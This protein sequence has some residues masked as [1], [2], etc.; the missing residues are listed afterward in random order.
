M[1]DTLRVAVVGAGMA[2]QAHAFGYRN[3]SMAHGL[4]PVRVELAC[5]VDPNLPLARSVAE[6]YGFASA[7][8]ELDAVLADPSIDVVSVA[9]PNLVHAE[10]LPKVLA[11]GK[12][13]FTEKPL[14]RRV[15]EARALADLA[16]SSG[17]RTGV[18]FSFRR[19]P[20]LAALADA[21]HAGAIGDVY[22]ARAWYQADYA[23]DPEG[24]F[25]W[26]YSLAES[27]G[28][29]IL[30]IGS[31]A[32][33]ALQ[34]VAGPVSAVRGAC[35]STVIPK[36]PVPS[37][38]VVGHG[39]AGTTGEYAEVTNDD[40]AVVLF[41][42]GGG[43]LAHLEVSRVAAGMPN[44]LGVTVYGSAGHASFDSITGGEFHIFQS[45]VADVLTNGPRRVFTG[46][47]HPYFADVAPMPGG[48]V[49]TGYGE[50]FVAEIQE[51]LHSVLT[52]QPMST[53]FD[54]AVATMAVVDA[55]QQ[56]AAS[57]A[58]REVG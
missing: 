20:G 13:L 55:A 10:V 36:R 37:R 22:S 11:A 50:A 57:G 9:L 47:Q 33:D 28:G 34:F 43:G 4:G 41:E 27:G 2:G 21:V 23:A 1:T 54:T 53:D 51:F 58:R 8:A 46:P 7:Q 56:V 52:G 16:R 40:I 3:A 29:A 18:G 35:L 25:S 26:R 14:G 12:H 5:V 6:R 48:G 44:S 31:H 15:E 49:G 38:A 19:L 45:G 42:L 39:D 17:V 24:P 32:I 30:D